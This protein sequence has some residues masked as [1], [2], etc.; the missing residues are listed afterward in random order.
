MSTITTSVSADRK[1]S[2]AAARALVD[3]WGFSIPSARVSKENWGNAG[4]LGSDMYVVLNLSLY[5]G[6]F[7]FFYINQI[8][9]CYHD[10][11]S[12]YLMYAY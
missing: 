5:F 12:N 9:P 4:I 3:D 11:N 10:Y 7:L 1:Q 8:Y 2:E 6:I